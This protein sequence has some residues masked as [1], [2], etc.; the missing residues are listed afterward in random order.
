MGLLLLTPKQF[1]KELFDLKN[2]NL[3]LD[4]EKIELLIAN[5][6]TARI[7]KN[8]H[9]ADRCRDELTAMGVVIEDTSNGTEWKIK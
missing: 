6:N 5:R 1:D 7:C 2:Q 3:N 4:I 8:W 9:E